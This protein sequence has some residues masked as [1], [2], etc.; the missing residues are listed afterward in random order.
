MAL[1]ATHIRFAL[2]MREGLGVTDLRK[3]LSGSM[4]PDSR[5]A[6]GVPRE[7]T[8][9][10]SMLSGDLLLLDDFRKG[11]A[12]HLAC[13]LAQ[14]QAFKRLFPE[15]LA[16][17]GS[18]EEKWLFRTA[19]KALQDI[20]DAGKFDARGYGRM[21]TWYETPNGETEEQLAFFYGL[22]TELYDNVD[23]K[24]DAEF[25]IWEQVGM[26]PASIREQRI[27]ASDLAQDP[28]AME[29]IGRLYD[30]TLACYRATLS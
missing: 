23:V 12:M 21:M 5:Y 27:L 7:A 29:R 2:E 17:V 16:R 9:D 25:D 13:D 24:V 15:E 8:H 14:A 19:L 11:W 18:D 26:P 3:Y 1:A 22:F 10:N 20:D 4:Y 30:E 28:S 6:T